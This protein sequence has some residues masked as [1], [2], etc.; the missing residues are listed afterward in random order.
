LRRGQQA[1]V[2]HLLPGLEIDLPAAG[3]RIDGAGLFDFP[4]RRIWL[5]VGFGAGEHLADQARAHPD[6]GFL[7]CEPFL[8][9]VARLLTAIDS[10]GIANIRIFRDDARLLLAALPEAGIDRAFVL[11]PD[12]WPKA[13][14][15]KRRFISPA[16]VAELARVLRDGAEFRVATDDAGYQAWI[17]QHVLAAGPFQWTAR[18]PADWR[19]RPAD[20]PGTRYEAK[21]LAAGRR[22]AYFCF[23]RK[24]RP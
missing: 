12:P 3:A 21:A 6:T 10:G 15:H 4:P 18:R 7:A 11:F 9:G 14:H 13:R 17:L 23:V 5:E 2:D 8:N 19:G 22:C 20:W 1:L 16:T 24:P